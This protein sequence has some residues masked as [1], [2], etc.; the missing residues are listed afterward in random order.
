MSSKG[1]GGGQEGEGVVLLRKELG[2]A[3]SHCRAASSGRGL[4]RLGLFSLRPHLLPLIRTL[5]A[6]KVP[7]IWKLA[8]SRGFAKGLLNLLQPGASAAR[9]TL[10]L[11]KKLYAWQHVGLANLISA[12]LL[13]VLFIQLLSQS[14]QVNLGVE[15]GGKVWV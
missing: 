1:G 13:A 2:P 3:H 8:R 10:F 6:A 9:V 12:Q 4:C 5:S 7:R 14:I 15:G 11:V